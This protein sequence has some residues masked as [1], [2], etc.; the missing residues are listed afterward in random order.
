M[1][2]VDTSPSHSVAP[3]PHSAS[4]PVT[5][6]LSASQDGQPVFSPALSLPA[7][8]RQSLAFSITCWLAFL[9]TFSYFSFRLF[10]LCVWESLLGREKHIKGITLHGS[11]L[12]QVQDIDSLFIS[13]IFLDMSLMR[14]LNFDRVNASKKL[15]KD[16]TVILVIRELQWKY[17]CEE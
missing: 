1:T 14:F 8:L 7:L 9:C 15:N 16:S 13:C 10:L 4:T 6:S 3:I 11:V 12:C 2:L 5:S 17:I